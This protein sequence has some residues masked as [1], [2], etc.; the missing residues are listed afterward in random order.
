MSY[1]T[2]KVPHRVTLLSASEQWVPV[3]AADVPI[4]LQQYTAPMIAPEIK[5][6]IQF[7][8]PTEIQ[9]AT[10]SA[11][12]FQND[13]FM[14][15]IELQHQNDRDWITLSTYNINGL[16]ASRQRV[17]SKGTRKRE[18]RP[19][20][21]IFE[22]KLVVRNRSE[23]NHRVVVAEPI[24]ELLSYEIEILPERTTQGY[25]WYEQNQAFLWEV[26]VPAGET[27]EILVTYKLKE[28]Q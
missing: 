10:A 12:L 21:Q 24:P 14:G 13:A 11:Q 9:V 28:Q 2:F 5:Q 16:T 23:Q 27:E 22:F 20:T 26:D 17:Q 1:R 3:A 4:T 6:N 18:S 25:V 8:I 15:V 7:A 19:D